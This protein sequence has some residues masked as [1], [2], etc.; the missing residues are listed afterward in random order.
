MT[1]AYS[2]NIVGAHVHSNLQ[3][4]RQA[5]AAATDCI[6]H[7]GRDRQYCGAVYLYNEARLHLALHYLT[8]V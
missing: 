5:G 3:A 7:S 6:Y 2:R 8:P 1:D 4:L